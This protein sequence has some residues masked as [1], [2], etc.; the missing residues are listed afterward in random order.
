MPVTTEEVILPLPINPNIIPIFYQYIKKKPPIMEAF[1]L[2][3]LKFI[4]MISL[5]KQF[6]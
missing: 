1:N 5:E 4:R 6:L 3:V 2:K